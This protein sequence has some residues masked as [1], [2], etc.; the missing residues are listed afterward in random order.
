MMRCGADDDE[1]SREPEGTADRDS[2]C[3][4]AAAG[5]G[6]VGPVHPGDEGFAALEHPGGWVVLHEPEG[7]AQL[8]EQLELVVAAGSIVLE[9]IALVSVV[10]G[11]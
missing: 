7:P 11:R 1:G 8:A 5:G 10:L 9:D 3:P 2:P 4:P 6:C